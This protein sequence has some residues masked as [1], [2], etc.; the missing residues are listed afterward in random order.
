MAIKYINTFQSKALQNLPKLV[1]LFEKT[2]GNR[3]RKACLCQSADE[4]QKIGKPIFCA[5]AQ[6]F[7]RLSQFADY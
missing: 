4:K 2:S 3:E 5:R 6:L 7:S 1:F